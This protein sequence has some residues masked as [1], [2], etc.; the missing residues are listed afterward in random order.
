MAGVAEL[1][2]AAVV[3]NGACAR[4]IG[5]CVLDRNAVI[6][7]AV[8]EHLLDAERQQL[9]GIGVLAGRPAE[10]LAHGV[11]SEVIA[12]GGREVADPAEGHSRAHVALGGQPECEVPARRMADRNGCVEASRSG[13]DVV[14]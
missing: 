6:V 3:A 10:E 4:R 13:S 12:F 11:V 7:H 2:Q 14:E 9:R 5:A 1:D 8:H